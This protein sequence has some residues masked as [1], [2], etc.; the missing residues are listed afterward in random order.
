[1]TFEEQTRSRSVQRVHR[2][3]QTRMYR[4]RQCSG[5]RQTK[6]VFKKFLCTVCAKVHSF[7]RLAPHLCVHEH[8]PLLHLQSTAHTH[9][10]F[11]PTTTTTPSR[12]RQ[13]DHQCTYN[14]NKRSSSLLSYIP[15]THTSAGVQKMQQ[16]Q[17]KH[18]R[19]AAIDVAAAASRLSLPP[20]PFPPS[21]F[22]PF[23]P[24][25]SLSIA[26]YRQPLVSPS[27]LLFPTL[28]PP[29]VCVLGFS[30]TLSHRSIVAPLS[31]AGG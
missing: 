11:P 13:T 27:P 10:L 25:C 23:S 20:F 15:H 8:F 26:S 5:R 14:N 29:P 1:M 21:A 30:T 22:L 19:T 17:H 4:I 31:E 28:L 9:L 18:T 12:R 2:Y 24:I 7:D 6:F 16:Q 3:R